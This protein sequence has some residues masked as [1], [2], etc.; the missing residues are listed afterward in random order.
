MGSLESDLNPN[1]PNPYPNIWVGHEFR[2]PGRVNFA[3][4]TYESM[5]ILIM[6]HLICK[7]Y[8]ISFI[9]SCLNLVTWMGGGLN[10]QSYVLKNRAQFWQILFEKQCETTLLLASSYPS[11]LFCMQMGWTFFHYAFHSH[12]R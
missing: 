4:S 3:G 6:I 1:L 7:Q 2:S 10:S 8:M 12:L 5:N 11:V 9:Y